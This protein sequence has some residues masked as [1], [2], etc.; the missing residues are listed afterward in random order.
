MK[1][2][3]K[4]WTRHTSRY[5]GLAIS[6]LAVWSSQGLAARACEI[7][8][9]VRAAA[10][11]RSDYALNP[12][13]ALICVERGQPASIATFG[14]L[15]LQADAPAITASTRF[16]IGSLTKVLTALQAAL[17]AERDQLDAAASLGETWP[18]AWPALNPALKPLPLQSLITHSSGLP[19]L[20]DNFQPADP[21]NP[22]ADYGLEHLQAFLSRAQPQARDYAYSNLG[23]GLLGALLAEKGQASGFKALLQRDLLQPL[24]MR[25]S[26]F[27][28]TAPLATGHFE[29]VPVKNWDFSDAAAAA[30]GLRASATDIAAFLSAQLSPPPGEL[31]AAIRRSQQALQSATDLPALKQAGQSGMAWGWHLQKAQSK[32]L[33]W[34]NGMT[35]GYLSHAIVD[36]EAGKA[37]AVLSSG[38]DAIQ[39]LAVGLMMPDQP[40]RQPVDQRL[41][42]AVLA[43]YTG[44]YALTPEV[45]FHISQAAGY[46]VVEITGQQAVR[47]FPTA[48]ADRFA[49][50]IVDA[51]LAF[52]RNARGQVTGLNLHQNGQIQPA[53]RL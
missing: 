53:Q 6:L 3:H 20:P 13:L 27:E 11:K 49:Y 40:P 9:A 16:E 29:G 44:R 48:T 22:Y 10:Q 38:T 23:Y 50:R 12:G 33:H 43:T 35:G 36:L 18:A 15:S 1:T 45:H 51:Q 47:V 37:V 30:G 34:H 46:L 14:R 8:E 19:R 26:T 32:T 5:L 2:T 42:E 52:V 21:S 39:D 41:P 25:H 28:N 31:G 24:N 17:L 4:K 7:P